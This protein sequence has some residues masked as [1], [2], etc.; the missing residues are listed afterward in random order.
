VKSKYILFF[1]LAL[2][3]FLFHCGDGD[4]QKIDGQEAIP[5][6]IA[7]V[8]LES[9][10]TDL[11]FAST[12]KAVDRAEMGT[13]V[14]GNINAV[15]VKEG[16]KVTKGTLLIELDGSDIEVK[17]A[18]ANAAYIEASAEFENTHKDM[19]RFEKLYKTK[20]VTQKELE[21]IKV[22]FESAQARKNAA[23]RTL[24]ET[25]KMLKYIRIEAPFNGVVTDIFI[26]EGDLATPG[27]PLIVVE[28]TGQYEV[29]AKIPEAAISSLEIGEAV[30][31]VI[32][33]KTNLQ[34]ARQFETTIDQITPS[35]DP[36]SHQFQITAILPNP[37][38]SIKPGMFARILIGKSG[39]QTLLIPTDALFIRG[40][41]EG[42][43]VVGAD[44]KAQ[45]RW[46][47][48]GRH[49][50]NQIEVLAGL[51]TGEMVV[52]ESDRK[53]RDGSRVEVQK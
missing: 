7:S 52:F 2:T 20:A 47:R 10:G 17:L 29:V 35:A 4:M 12:V 44:S 6:R 19:K 18:Q 22:H 33:A 30:S 48:T 53:L 27:S 43:F 38:E 28:K 13:K 9:A 50:G 16:Q 8:L 36:A 21:N 40:Q 26:D 25:R 11:Q 51:D 3:L 45:L 23:K 42:V 15:H 39:P 5:V 41:L 31:V 1:P 24:D 49:F 14:M 34:A 37:D 46:I 32:P